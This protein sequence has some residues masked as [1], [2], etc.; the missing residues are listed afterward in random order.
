M[1]AAAHGACRPWRPGLALLIVAL[2]ACNA[3][4]PTQPMTEAPCADAR[5]QLEMGLCWQRAAADREAT[6]EA[7]SS[8]VAELL[9][10]RGGP[11]ARAA[12][13]QAQV[14]WR[15]YRDAAC[16]VQGLS[17]AGGSLQATAAALCRWRL[18]GERAQTL[19]T[20]VDERPAAIP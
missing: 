3:A 9:A 4:G 2:A 5:T 6:V 16:E 11:S 10:S 15:R 19:Q 1:T 14:E 13:E 7:Q 20:L 18:S 8:R 17:T 12:A